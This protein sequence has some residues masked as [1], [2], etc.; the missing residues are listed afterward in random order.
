M[1][2]DKTVGLGSDYTYN[3]I[4]TD[5][6]R[7]ASQLVIYDVIENSLT[8]GTFDWKG[9]F[10]GIDVSAI[11]EMADD[12]SSA[13]TPVYCKPKIYYCVKNGRLTRMIM[14]GTI[15]VKR[16]SADSA[17]QA[18][19]YATKKCTMKTVVPTPRTDRSIINRQ[20]SFRA[21]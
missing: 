10:Q 8:G 5:G 6:Q 9:T 7:T 4:F 17:S 20:C 18:F 21:D 15:T 14:T 13:S 16:R 3:V 11:S 1:V 2:N 12:T 19:R